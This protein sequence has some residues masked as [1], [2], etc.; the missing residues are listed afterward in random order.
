[1]A[2][3]AFRVLEILDLIA[4]RPSGATH[5]EISAALKIPKSSLTSLLRDL[6][7]PGYLQLSEGSGK[8]M[9]GPQVLFLSNAYLKNL[10]I[11]R[12]A[13]PFVRRIFL[14]VN[15]FTSL[16]IP[17]EETGVIVCAESSPS[18]LAHALNIGERTPT[19]ASAAGKAVLAFLEADEVDAFIAKNK[20]V[21]HTTNTLM[22]AADIRKDLAHVREAGLAYSREEYLLGIT[23]IASPVFNS[24]GRPVASLAVALPTARLS[25]KVEAKITAA[26]LKEGAALSKLLGVAPSSHSAKP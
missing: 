24:M 2:K 16:V 22:R 19:L 4:Q 6:Q 5:T 11:V 17:K 9:I 20:P 12:L 13:E 15:E 18:P 1:M 3:S 7:L 21:A 8:Y 25:A 10:N 26:L 14:A 23:S